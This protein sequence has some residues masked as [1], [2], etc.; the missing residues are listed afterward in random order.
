LFTLNSFHSQAY[1]VEKVKL[2]H[3]AVCRKW[4]ELWP[5]DWILHHDNAPANKALSVKAVSGPKIDNW[6]GTP[7]LFP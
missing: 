3:E 1:Y 5:N 6:D 4:P 7:T 2:V